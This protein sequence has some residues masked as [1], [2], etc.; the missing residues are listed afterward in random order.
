ALRSLLRLGAQ[1]ANVLTDAGSEMTVPASAVKVGQS[2]IVRPGER[3]PT[4]GEVTV[5]TSTIG[6]SLLTGESVPVEVGA[7]DTVIGGS[8]NAGGR[9]VVTAT[10]IGADT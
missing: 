3:I 6:A 8:V 7:G 1:H 5:G 10:R 9:L 4:D 2:L